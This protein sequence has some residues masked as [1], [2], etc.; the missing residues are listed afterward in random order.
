MTYADPVPLGSATPPGIQAV[1]GHGAISAGS[2]PPEGSGQPERKPVVDDLAGRPIGTN[3]DVPTA[4]L[5]ASRVLC[6]NLASRHAVEHAGL[7]VGVA[8]QVREHMTPRPFLQPRGRPY[9]VITEPAGHRLEAPLGAGNPDKNLIYAH[10]GHLSA[11]SIIRP[12]HSAT[13]AAGHNR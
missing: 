12:C 3:F 11:T 6:H 13:T 4:L 2:V 8:S 7:T 1:S 9:I 10:R 5:V